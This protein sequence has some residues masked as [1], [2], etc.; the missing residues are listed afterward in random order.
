MAGRVIYTHHKCGTSWLRKLVGLYALEAGERVYITNHL[1]HNPEK[2][3]LIL[4][5][6]SSYGHVEYCR[7]R[8]A[9]HVIRHPLDIVV[10]A[11]YSH[12]NTHPEEGWPQLAAQRKKLQVMDREQ[13][14]INTWLFLESCSSFGKHGLPGPLFSM[15]NWD[16]TDKNID[17]LLFEDISRYNETMKE[18]LAAFF[19]RDVSHLLDQITF[20]ILSGGRKVGEIDNKS[21]FRSGRPNQWRDELPPYIAAA[22]AKAYPQ[23]LE[24]FYE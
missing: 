3:D 5:I 9:L 8:T 4:F 11:Y 17:T 18:K 22:I 1:K 12:L 15:R 14:I 2:Y 13:G 24:R 6:N 16:Y 7:D 23:I 19:G 20:E 10:S 21:H